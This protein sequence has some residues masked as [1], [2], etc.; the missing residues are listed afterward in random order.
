MKKLPTILSYLFT[1]LLIFS[2]FNHLVQPEFYA[3]MIPDFI[4][5]NLANIASF[6]VELVI[7]ILLI[8]P[9]YRH[10]GGLGFM[11][12]MIAFMPIHIWDYTKDVPMVGSKTGAIIRL[13]VQVLFIYGGWWIYKKTK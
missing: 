3:P 11:L 9:K 4:P 8:V 1:A 12:L 13:V 5:A 6:V 10:I 7:G 2:A